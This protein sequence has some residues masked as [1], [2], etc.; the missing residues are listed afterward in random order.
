[1]AASSSK[2]IWSTPERCYG[3]EQLSSIPNE[4]YDEIFSYIPTFEEDERRFLL[5]SL[6]L[7]CR[8]FCS[9][10]LPIKFHTLHFDGRNHLSRG[11]HPTCVTFG[12]ALNRDSQP[13]KAAA[14]LVQECTF[15]DWNIGH[16]RTLFLSIYDQALRHM[17]NIHTLSLVRTPLTKDL[18]KSIAQLRN[19]K[20]LNIDQRDFRGGRVVDNELST[21]LLAVPLKSVKA[22]GADLSTLRLIRDDVEEW[23]EWI[24]SALCFWVVERLHTDSTAI[25]TAVFEAKSPLTILDLECIQFRDDLKQ[26]AQYLDSMPTLEELS[27]H[28]IDMLLDIMPNNIVAAAPPLPLLPTSL[29][30]LTKLLCSPYHAKQFRGCPLTEVH[31]TGRIH[32]RIDWHPIILFEKHLPVTDMATPRSTARFE[33]LSAPLASFADLPTKAYSHLEKISIGLTR[34]ETSQTI[35]AILKDRSFEAVKKVSLYD[36]YRN[37]TEPPLPLFPVLLAS[38]GKRRF[39]DQLTSLFPVLKYVDFY[40]VCQWEC[41]GEGWTQLSEP[42]F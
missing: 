15:S 16:C 22:L 37:T 7:V 24:A 23:A 13:A 5:A 12:R 29:P 28:R 14:C 8:Y 25:A 2:I 35:F 33:S 4:K 6:S 42:S 10:T 11:S 38:S 27:I 19:L 18:V 17:T 9:V 21:R 36:R 39:I 26:F 30:S 41:R 3:D 20:H 1:M 34:G 31:L 40:G 32:D